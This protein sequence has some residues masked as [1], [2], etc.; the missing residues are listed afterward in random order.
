MPPWA[1]DEACCASRDSLWL[2]DADLAA[3]AAW[4]EQDFPMGDPA[5]YRPGPWPRRTIRARPTGS[6][7]LPRPTRPTPR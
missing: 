6:T 2:P 4:A 7:R 5:D 1:L 3:F